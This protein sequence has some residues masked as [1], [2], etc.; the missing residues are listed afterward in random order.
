M[1]PNR[2]FADPAAGMPRLGF[3][4]PSSIS[5]SHGIFSPRRYRKLDLTV[6]MPGRG[7]LVHD[8]PADAIIRLAPASGPQNLT[9]S[10]KRVCVSE[11]VSSLRVTHRDR[12]RKSL[13]LCLSVCKS[14]CLPVCHRLSL[15]LSLSFS[16]SV[17]LCPC[18]SAPHCSSVMM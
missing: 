7:A 17:S 18:P 12:D 1:T 2:A 9:A 16:E 3:S 14:A 10:P 5:C 6:T 8:S 11:A 15:S 13:S 4:Y